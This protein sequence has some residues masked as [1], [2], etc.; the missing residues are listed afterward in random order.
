MDE[1]AASRHGAHQGPDDWTAAE[2]ATIG[3]LGSSRRTLEQILR[4]AQ[5]QGSVDPGDADAIRAKVYRHLSLMASALK[6][7]SDGVRAHP[8]R[9]DQ[10][11]DLVEREIRPIVADIVT[12]FAPEQNLVYFI[13]DD[14]AYTTTEQV[15]QLA[16]LQEDLSATIADYLDVLEGID[17]GGARRSKVRRDFMAAFRRVQS[18]IDLIVEELLA[19][20]G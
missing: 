6:P 16:E 4:Q 17:R 7:I 3:D 2:P 8:P 9:T 14:E 12:L 19:W 15:K 11:L 18:K 13:D 20:R 10:E 5:A 1:G